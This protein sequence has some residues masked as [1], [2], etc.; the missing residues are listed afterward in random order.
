MASLE[1]K[2]GLALMEKGWTLAVAESCTGGLLGAWLTSVP[3]CSKY[4]QGGVIAYSNQM[5]QDLLGVPES[6]LVETGAVSK[7]TAL[8][9]AR[10]LKQFGVDVGIAITGVAG[11]DGGTEA[12]PVGTTWIGLFTPISE[13]AVL[14]SGSGNRNEI[15][16]QSVQAAL[17]LAVRVVVGEDESCD[18]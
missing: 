2:L 10:G 11:P 17:E 12:K 3:G 8:A 9:M 5:R 15:R 13:Y 14:H 16:M 7:E 1:R 6:V 4:F 18:G